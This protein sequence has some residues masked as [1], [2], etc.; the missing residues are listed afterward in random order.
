MKTNL[1]FLENLA[2]LEIRQFKSLFSRLTPNS[3]LTLKPM[4]LVG[5]DYILTIE[6]KLRMD[7]EGV[8][9]IDLSWKDKEKD[10]SQTIEVVKEVKVVKGISKKE[11]HIY[12]FKQSEDLKSRMVFYHEGKFQNRKEFKH[13]YKIKSQSKFDRRVKRVKSG[14]PS[15][16][17]GRR[18]IRGKLT[19][20]GKRCLRYE[21]AQLEVLQSLYGE[22][23]K[24][25]E[26]NLAELREM[27]KDMNKKIKK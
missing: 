20:Y 22:L 18:F 3:S 12:Y 26:E 9:W 8:I 4:D 25:Q 1:V 6:P 7:S 16:K 13:T 17:Y 27:L 11:G 23:T 19:K 21:I 10:C 24:A 2:R 5:C 15:K 14:N